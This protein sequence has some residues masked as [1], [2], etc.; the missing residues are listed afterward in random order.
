MLGHFEVF[1]ISTLWILSS[2]FKCILTGFN[3]ERKY[4]FSIM[5][6]FLFYRYF[7]GLVIFYMS[8]ILRVLWGTLWLER[9]LLLSLGQG[10][11]KTPNFFNSFKHSR[12]LTLGVELNQT[13]ISK[14]F[15][16]KISKNKH[17]TTHCP[18]FLVLHFVNLFV[19]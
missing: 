8:N 7:I 14:E 1:K 19:E 6:L 5:I 17:Y 12:K 4:I 18:V 10:Q 16:N 3:I 2:V 9:V 15:S 13:K 11:A